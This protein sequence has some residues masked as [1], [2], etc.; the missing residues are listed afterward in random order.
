MAK[1]SEYRAKGVLKETLARDRPSRRRAAASG[2][3]VKARA[4]AEAP[5]T[6]RRTGEELRAY[7][8]RRDFETSPEPK[9]RKGRAAGARFVVQ[10]H[11]ARRLHYDLRLE[12]DGVLKSWAVTRGPSLVPGE[13]RLAVHT[14]DHPLQYLA[15]EGA[16]P[17]GQYGGGTMIVWDRGRWTP[18]G[19]PRAGYAKGHLAF[20]L[21]GERLGGRW[22]LI[23][24]KPRGGKEQ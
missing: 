22:H 15:F 10:K 4:S 12:L 2:A 6:A 11:D 5:S 21:D 18:E 8:E 19:D 16:I 24:T 7:R 20:T 14:E 3:D 1:A 9:G 23:R 17:K 13:R